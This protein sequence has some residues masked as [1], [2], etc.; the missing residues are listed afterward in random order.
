[1]DQCTNGMATKHNKE[2]STVNKDAVGGRFMGSLRGKTSHYFPFVKLVAQWRPY[3]K[4][5]R[6]CHCGNTIAAIG[7]YNIPFS[8][9]FEQLSTLSTTSYYPIERFSHRR[10]IHGVTLLQK[11]LKS[12]LSLRYCLFGENTEDVATALKFGQNFYNSWL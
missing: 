6:L 11:K 3:G 7:R 10:K 9:V 12:R 5:R 2:Q 8:E 1:M 4:A